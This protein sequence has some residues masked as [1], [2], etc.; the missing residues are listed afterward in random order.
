MPTAKLVHVRHPEKEE[1]LNMSE[2]ITVSLPELMFIG[3]NSRNDRVWGGMLI[4]NLIS[5]NKRKIV[6]APLFAIGL[7][8]TIPIAARIFSQR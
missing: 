1:E 7:L 5:R 8:T 2:K 3:A 6:G 4:S